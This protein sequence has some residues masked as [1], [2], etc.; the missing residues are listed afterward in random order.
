MLLME[1][2]GRK[3]LDWKCMGRT[4]L[5]FFV[6]LI[7][8]SCK[9]EEEVPD[10][11][12]TLNLEGPV[13]R[14]AFP[15]SGEVFSGFEHHLSG[16]RLTFS[17]L[18]QD[19]SFR[20]ENDSL[21]GMELALPAGTYEISV[22]M[23]PASLYGQDWATFSAATREVTI[24]P[25]T[26]FIVLGLKPDCALFLVYDKFNKL[27]QGA[28][29]IERHSY[30]DG[31]FTSTPLAEDTESGLYYTYFTPDPDT[32]DPS[33][34]LWFYD[35]EPGEQEGGLPTAGLESG[36]RYDIEVLD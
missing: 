14:Q 10:I 32:D 2:W 33:A 25:E 17:S 8:I 11:T 21:E 5:I 18:G 36:S 26:G 6:F 13:F 7:L 28:F 9:R 4:G 1:R 29:M 35:G 34:F 22:Q 24:T 30:A 20:F 19:Y 12:F 31:Y 16:G 15:D 3:E 23:D 27:D